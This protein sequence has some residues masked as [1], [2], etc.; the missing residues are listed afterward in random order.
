M[1]T[2]LGLRV[3]RLTRLSYGPVQLGALAPGTWRY[4]TKD[5]RRAIEALLGG[6]DGGHGPRR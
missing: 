1:A 5:E 4:L 6:A 2:V 3:E